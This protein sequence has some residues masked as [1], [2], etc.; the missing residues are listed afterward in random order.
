MKRALYGVAL[1][2]SAFILPWWI[3]VL[4]S[5]LGILYFPQLYEVIAVGLI[6]DTLYGANISLHGVSI[7]FTIGLTCALYALTNIK[8]RI[9]I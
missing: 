4:F 2:I 1:L 6:L 5:I 8:S 9:F 7:V 3:A